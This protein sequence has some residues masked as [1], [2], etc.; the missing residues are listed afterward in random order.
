M[1]VPPQTEAV[2]LAL[3]QEELKE[4]RG[5]LYRLRKNPWDCHPEEPPL[6]LADDEGS[7]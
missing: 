2:P 4:K 1:L 3:A 5:G 7:P 6:L